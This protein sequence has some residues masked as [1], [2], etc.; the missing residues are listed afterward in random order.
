M[1]TYCLHQMLI[2]Q[3]ASLFQI[4]N[5]VTISS[6]IK[7]LPFHTVVPNLHE[8]RRPSDKMKRPRQPAARQYTGPL[9]LLNFAV[10]ETASFF[11]YFS[12]HVSTWKRNWIND[13]KR[14]D[15][16]KIKAFSVCRYYTV[17]AH[18]H[19][20]PVIKRGAAKRRAGAF[21]TFGRKHYNECLCARYKGG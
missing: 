10:N 6:E 4:C 12:R 17:T 1:I 8:K 2:L 15:S 21:R 13:G 16:L 5:A 7:S 20:K 9:A 14:V 11:R 18:L 3:H 19:N